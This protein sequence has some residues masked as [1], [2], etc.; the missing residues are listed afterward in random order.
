ML[1][2]LYV[3]FNIWKAD[4]I[5]N[6]ENR[7]NSKKGTLLFLNICLGNTHIQNNDSHT[8]FVVELLLQKFKII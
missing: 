6:T 4:L 8:F 7:S 2:C 5:D 3:H 1:F